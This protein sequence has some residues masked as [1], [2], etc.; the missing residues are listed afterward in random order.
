MQTTI[1]LDS[2]CKMQNAV[3]CHAVDITKIW[4]HPLRICK[5]SRTNMLIGLLK[6][7]L[8]HTTSMCCQNLDTP[9]RNLQNARD[10]RGDQP[11]TPY[12]TD[13]LPLSN[14]CGWIELIFKNV[15]TCKFCAIL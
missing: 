2:K 10:K 9:T 6:Y 8:H 1:T 5:V 7:M 12:R 13:M 3:L 15:C 4:I 11:A 14:W